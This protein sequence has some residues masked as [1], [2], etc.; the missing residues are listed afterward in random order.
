MDPMVLTDTMAHMVHMVHIGPM[1][2]M[3]HMECLVSLIIILDGV[4]DGD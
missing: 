3:G 2:L 4:W 1:D